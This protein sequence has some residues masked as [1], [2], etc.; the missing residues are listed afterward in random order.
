MGL[1]KERGVLENDGAKNIS[2]FS[3]KFEYDG[4]QFVTVT[5]ISET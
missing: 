3:D 2:G 5:L 1:A 4:K